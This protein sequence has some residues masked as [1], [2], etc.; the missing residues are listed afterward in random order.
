MRKFDGFGLRREVVFLMFHNNS[1]A[2]S[3]GIVEPAQH[4]TVFIWGF[5]SVPQSGKYQ[6]LSVRDQ[7]KSATQELNSIRKGE[8]EDAS[9]RGRTT[10]LN[11]RLHQEETNLFQEIRANFYDPLSSLVLLLL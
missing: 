4:S 1:P 11:R 7:H 10:G 3:G 5:F 8:Y 9:T 2:Y 6:K